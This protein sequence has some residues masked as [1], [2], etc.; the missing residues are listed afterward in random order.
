MF[1]I[2]CK[3]CCPAAATLVKSIAVIALGIGQI[4]SGFS[5]KYVIVQWT[6]K[7]LYKPGLVKIAST[8]ILRMEKKAWGLKTRSHKSGTQSHRKGS[9]TQWCK[10]MLDGEWG[11]GQ[12]AKKKRR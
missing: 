8:S 1:Q 2:L 11:Y 12:R 10:V 3:S 9:P 7:F 6:E 4:E 5:N